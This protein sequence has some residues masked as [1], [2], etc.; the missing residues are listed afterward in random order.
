[1]THKLIKALSLATALVVPTFAAVT[2]QVDPTTGVLPINPAIYGKNHGISDDPAT[3]TPDSTISL[4]K[5][6][7]VKML[8]LSG[9]NNQTKYNWRKK[10]SSHPDWFNNV[11]AHDWDFSAQEVQD[12][13]PGVQGLFSL[14]LIGWAASN[15]TNNWSDYTWGSTHNGSYPSVGFDLAGGGNV[16]ADGLTMTT[17]G[18]PSKYLESWPADSTVGILGHWFGAGGVGLDSNRF[19]YWNMDNEPDIWSGTHNDVV[20]AKQPFDTFFAKYVAVAKAA[21]AKWPN[22]QLVGPVLT[23]EWQ[24]WTWEGSVFTVGTTKM[25]GME[26]FLYRLGQEEKSSGVKLLD[27][28]DMHYY[29]EYNTAAKNHDLLQLSRMYWDTTYNWPGSNGIHMIDGKWG[30]AV[31]NYVYLRIQRWMESYLGAGR[32]RLAMTEF[33]AANGDGTADVHAVSY[34]SMLGSF[35]D[36]GFEMFTP[37]DWYSGWYEVLHLYTSYAKPYRVSSTS[38]LDTLVSAYSSINKTGDSLTVILVNRDEANAQSATVNLANFIPKGTQAAA[39]SL[40]GLSGETFV[41]AAQNALQSQTVTV[42][43][44]AFTMSLPKL[45]VTAVVLTTSTPVPPAALLNTQRNQSFEARASHGQLQLEL[46]SAATAGQ[47]RLL[48]TQG[49]EVTH[50]TLLSGAS[51]PVFALPAHCQGTYLV[52]VPGIGYRTINVIR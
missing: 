29:P 45:S 49:A 1:M 47:V 32:G 30:T 42:A 5:D 27:V 44:N 40:S 52:Q 25:S 2:L 21:R 14:Q 33:G 35:A 7:G 37:W 12:R 39:F 18:T 31:P 23:N 10:I 6:A 4:Y 51:H 38:T 28:W 8:R 43:S 19:R 22:I 46:P 13:L 50:W 34:A 20:T 24:W 11:Y 36:H 16:S 15:D 41:S 17:A 48:N 26:Y 3:S 9:G